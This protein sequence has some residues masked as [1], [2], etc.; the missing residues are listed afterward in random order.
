MPLWFYRL[1]WTAYRPVTMICLFC[2][3]PSSMNCAPRMMPILSRKPPFSHLAWMSRRQNWRLK[4]VSMN[5]YLMN[6]FKSLPCVCVANGKRRC[7]AGCNTRM[8]LNYCHH[9]TLF[10]K[11]CNVGWKERICAACGGLPLK[12]LADCWTRLSIMICTC[13]AF[14][15]V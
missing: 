3:Y 14:L 5:R 11:H 13:V 9:F 2:Y 15:P 1:T 12:L 6:H 10:A 7:S 4:P 8:I